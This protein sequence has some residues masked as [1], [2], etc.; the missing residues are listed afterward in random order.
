MSHHR[1]GSGSKRVQHIAQRQRGLGSAIRQA[2]AYLELNRRIQPELPTE[3]R[4]HIQIACIEGDCLMIAAAS[5]VWATRARMLSNEILAA[6]NRLWPQPLKSARVFIA[7][8]P[9]DDDSFEN[10]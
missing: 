2:E 10:G 4:G 7:E 3:A 5:P 1:P 9:L 6:T 8:A